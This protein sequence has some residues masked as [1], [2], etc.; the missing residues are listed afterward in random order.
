MWLKTI[1]DTKDNLEG[2]YNVKWKKMKIIRHV[3]TDIEYKEGKP[4]IKIIIIEQ[5]NT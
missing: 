1:K 3:I 5:Q 4:N 2:T